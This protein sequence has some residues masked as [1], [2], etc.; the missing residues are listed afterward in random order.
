MHRRLFSLLAL[1]AVLAPMS[2]VTAKPDAFVTRQLQVSGTFTAE[3]T[4]YTVQAIYRLR[5]T[6]SVGNPENPY[7]GLFA[8]NPA[9]ETVDVRICKAAGCGVL[10]NVLCISSVAGIARDQGA[11]MIVDSS[12]TPC[13]VT[14]EATINGASVPKP[15][16]VV[17]F[18]TITSATFAVGATVAGV[19]AA[20][21][22][23]TM[24]RT[25]GIEPKTA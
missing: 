22:N 20:T 3:G 17:T 10:A 18:A 7:G 19:S 14:F 8:T 12:E 9:E 6:A 5:T 15:D 24:T 21:S 13:K 11:M 2:P 23:G 25:L 1:V 4:T 16:G